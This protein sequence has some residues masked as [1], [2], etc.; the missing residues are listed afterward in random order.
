MLIKLLSSVIQ[1][2][3]PLTRYLLCLSDYSF[4]LKRI[5]SMSLSVCLNEKYIKKEREL[6]KLAWEISHSKDKHYDV[7]QVDSGKGWSKYLNNR[8]QVI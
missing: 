2:D 7:R 3:F 4:G 6:E 8:K 5:L 1:A